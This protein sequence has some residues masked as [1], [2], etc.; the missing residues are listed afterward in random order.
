MPLLKTLPHS[1]RSLCKSPAF[2]ATCIVSLALGI[3]ANVTIYS[4]VREMIL[5]DIS[6]REPDRLARVAAEISYG[7]Y[8]DLRAAGVFKD[9]A[10]DV[11]LHDVSWD[12][13]TR[14][15]VAWH[16]THSRRKL[17]LGF[18]QRRTKASDR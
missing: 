4:I 14:G 8:R 17:Q 11:G 5:G 6:A 9:L 13:G 18:A 1:L 2:A 10:F 16:D 15:E 3:G 7:R 12:T